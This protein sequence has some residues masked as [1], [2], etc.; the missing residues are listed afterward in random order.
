MRGLLRQGR[1]DG[2][3]GC[4]AADDNDALSGIIKAVAV[5]AVST[6]APILRVDDRAGKV[7]P[8]RPTPAYNPG[9]SDSSQYT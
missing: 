8:A 5:G 1:H 6:R 3:R 4:A 2:H 9:R 7:R